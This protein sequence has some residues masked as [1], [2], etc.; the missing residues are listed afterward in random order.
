LKTEEGG[1]WLR[2][3]SAST[4]ICACIK[5]NL[6]IHYPTRGES[7]CACQAVKGPGYDTEDEAPKCTHKEKCI[8]HT[9]VRVIKSRRMRLVG[10]VAYIIKMH[11]GTKFR[12]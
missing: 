4:A 1:D 12:V 10:H 6:Q 9:N 11:N 5:F 2:G 3:V 8:L 7:V